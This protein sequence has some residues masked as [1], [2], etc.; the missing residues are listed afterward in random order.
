MTGHRGTGWPGGLGAR[1]SFATPSG[2]FADGALNL[3]ELHQ[4]VRATASPRPLEG[5]DDGLL[6]WLGYAPDETPIDP[7]N[8]GENPYCV[9]CWATS[10]RWT[11]VPDEAPALYQLVGFGSVERYSVAHALSVLRGELPV[12]ERLLEDTLFAADQ[13]ARA[14]LDAP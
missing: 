4:L 12:P 8:P 5:P 10:V 3:T 2:P 13:A 11:E 6:H 14:G 9:G 7:T 1:G